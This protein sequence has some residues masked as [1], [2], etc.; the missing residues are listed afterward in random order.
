MLQYYQPIS[1]TM[2][3]AGMVT[4]TAVRKATSY[5]ASDC[6]EELNEDL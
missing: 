1:L 4:H 5:Y 3:Q 6:S 2:N